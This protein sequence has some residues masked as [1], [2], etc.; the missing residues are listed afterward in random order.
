MSG[1]NRYRP[2]NSEP[3]RVINKDSDPKTDLTLRGLRAFIAVQESGSI[4]G[5]AKRLN[6]STSGVSQQITA[7]EK[8]VGAQLFDRQTR[9][10][11]LTPAG[12]ILRVH[13]LKVL[14]AVSDA[15][16]ELAELNLADL[17]QLSLAI[18]D[19]LDASL[20]PVIV[21]S[22]RDRFSGCFV[23]T[24]SGRSDWVMNRLEQRKADIA[25]TSF[26]P[27]D[28]NQIRT[29]P[30]LRETYILV[31][32]KGVIIGNNSEGDMR[33]QLL[34]IP[35]VQYS[36]A[37]PIGRTVAQHLNRLRF[38]A[39]RRFAFEASRSVFA[40]VVQSGG[41]TLTTPLNLLD[42]ERFLK[43]IDVFPMPFPSVSRTVSLAARTEELGQ[44]PERLAA[45]CRQLIADRIIPHFADLAP[46][47]K[48]AITL[49]KS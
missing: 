44:L 35:F 18:I 39:P 36:D 29:I 6:G 21:A 3:K 40:M 34:R 41:W 37:M 16:A 14:E 28:A 46:D 13:A 17:P 42:A 1:S 32:A 10:L 26:P 2:K 49:A 47:I 45:D 23:N 48:N 27:V 24:F 25:V 19:D 7:L 33:D 31:A 22:L 9:P 20:T 12:Q 15:Q 43:D 4:S 38:N 8:T 11:R 5:A 30:I